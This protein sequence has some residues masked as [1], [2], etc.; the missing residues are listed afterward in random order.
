MIFDRIIRVMENT[1]GILPDEIR[2][3]T[4]R[5]ALFEFPGSAHE[6]LKEQAQPDIER[7]REEFFLPFPV[8]AV[9]DKGTCCILV[10][11]V[12]DQVGLDQPRKFIHYTPGDASPDAFYDGAKST[13]PLGIDIMTFGTVGMAPVKSAG[14]KFYIVGKVSMSLILDQNGKI[15]D[16]FEVVKEAEDSE[17]RNAFSSIEEVLYFNTQD[18]F[19]L[20][21]TPVRQEKGRLKH[22]PRSHERPLYTILHPG[23]IRKLMGMPEIVNERGSPEPHWRRAH[24][25]Q[26][27]SERFVKARGKVIRVP[28][29]WI[30]A[31]EATVNGKRYRVL[32]DR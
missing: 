3:L 1:K 9:E 18:K 6:V 23:E 32:L 8:T 2:G 7:M 21:V 22:C 14:D 16:Q 5:A 29:R 13:A 19:I 17:L 25:R 30:G 20:E 11:M 12:K 4:R 24:T 27:R 31:S 15:V 28:A 26:L 10:D